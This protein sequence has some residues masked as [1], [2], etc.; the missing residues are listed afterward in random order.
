M[1]RVALL[2]VLLFAP[3]AVAHDYWLV[4]DT[5]APKDGLE[6]QQ[7]WVYTVEVTALKAGDARFQAELRSATLSEPVVVQQSTTVFAAGGN[8]PA[9]SG[10]R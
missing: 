1:N 7:T 10:A 8:R 3:P 9:T 4:P 2:A 6:P 5:F